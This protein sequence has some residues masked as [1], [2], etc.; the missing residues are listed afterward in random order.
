[1]NTYPLSWQTT[2]LRICLIVGLSISLIYWI[3]YSFPV[4]PP[5][6]N[7]SMESPLGRP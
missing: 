4:T 5:V 7:V 3:D 2:L 1:M 6:E